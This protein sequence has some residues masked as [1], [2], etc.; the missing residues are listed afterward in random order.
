MFL[1]F[2][3]LMYALISLV[4][5]LREIVSTNHKHKSYNINV[6][7]NPLTKHTLKIIKILITF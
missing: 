2:N 4:I 5:S 3:E 6:I 7:I 1:F